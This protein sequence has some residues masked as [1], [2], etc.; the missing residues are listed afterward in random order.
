M[1][2][3]A[4]VT[5]VRRAA[6]IPTSHR[7]AGALCAGLAFALVLRATSWTGVVAALA[8]AAV[9]LLDARLRL[10]LLCV[11]LFVS[12]WWLASVR[13]GSLDASRLAPLIGRAARAILEVSG[14]PR[15]NG[16]SIR[17]PVRVRSV[18]DERLV[19][20]SVL[21]L[22]RS[23]AKPAQGA[24]LEALVTVRA[25]RGPSHAGGFDERTYLARQGVHAVL[26]ADS[27][28]RVGRRAGLAGL[29][30]TI[31]ARLVAGI[32]PGLEGERRALVEGLVLGQDEELDASLRQR[33]RDSG[34]YHLLAVSGQNVAYLAGIAL[35]L[36]W[37]IGL[38]RWAGE[39][40]ALA[41]IAAY[42]AAVGWQPSVVR[43]GVAGGLVSLAWLSA[44]PLDRWHFALLGAATLLAWN[45]YSLLDAGFQLSF[46]AVAAIF[47]FVPRLERTLAGY[48]LPRR[49]AAV[50]AVAAACGGVTAPILWWH[51]G[52][53]P[54]LTVLANAL[55]EPVVAPILSLGLAAA[56]A[57]PVSASAATAIA[58]VNGWLAEYLAWCARSVG[59]IPFARLSSGAAVGWLLAGVCLALT[60][61]RLPPWW[62]KPVLAAATAAAA[63]L[64]TWKL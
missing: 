55:A 14:P 43:A 36:G 38:P 62:R 61:R 51:F 44:R 52:S 7:L 12:G 45:P 28:R 60:V 56:L 21:D 4:A 63:G 39:V 34:L 25:P 53:V 8:A 5:L 49:L 31:R 16:F 50:V 2:V 42:V 35:L 64:A 3:V 48:P 32:A 29:G 37:L 57:S 33:F 27:Y 40:G 17:V 41:S 58:W 30:D 26:H 24:V 6:A 20:R 19:E 15:R 13:L 54:V 1:T 10:P 22:P 23:A 18:W 46:A 11:S 47:V 59:S 9:A